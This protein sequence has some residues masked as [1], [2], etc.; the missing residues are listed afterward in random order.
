MPKLRPALLLSLAAALLLA[1]CFS[2]TIH[3]KPGVAVAQ[4]DRDWLA[5]RVKAEQDVPPRMVTQTIP[6]HWI[7]GRKHCPKPG[8][9]HVTP[10]Y[11]TPPRFYTE[12]INEGLRA[13]AAEQCMVE[14]GYR[15][16]TLPPCPESVARAA[17]PGQTVVL[18]RLTP[19]S[20]VVNRGQ[21]WVIV[22]RG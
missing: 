1:G 4:A 3:Y 6:G 2:R 22:N 9:C 5:C 19:Q 17:P 18:P 8:Q 14:R 12:D 16:I 15:K 13:H 20:C 21:S 10:G 11:W 7:P